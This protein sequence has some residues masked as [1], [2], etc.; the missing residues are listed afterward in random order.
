M[1][2]P[3]YEGYGGGLVCGIRFD[4]DFDFDFDTD[5]DAGGHPAAH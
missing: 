2:A 4:F 1:A 3:K 5:T